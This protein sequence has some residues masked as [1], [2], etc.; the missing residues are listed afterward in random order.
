[1]KKSFIYAALALLVGLTACKPSEPTEP[2]K[3][4]VNPTSI[5]ILGG[6][7]SEVTVECTASWEATVNV[8]WL[9]VTPM[10]GKSGSTV[11]KIACKSGSPRSATVTFSSGIS[12]AQVSVSRV[13]YGH[14]DEEG[15]DLPEELTAVDLGLSS[16][17]LWANINVGGTQPEDCGSY[18]A[19]GET[20]AKDSYSWD[21]YKWGNDPFEL[22]KY[23]TDP[24]CGTVDNYSTLL[25]ADDAAT[26][27][28]GSKWRMPT[29]DEMAELLNE[30]EWRSY[31]RNGVKGYKIIG[32]NDNIIFLPAAGRIE[33]KPL[34]L[35]TGV[36]YWTSTLYDDNTNS[37]IS[38]FGTQ[39]FPSGADYI[40]EERSA[41]LPI[42][43]VRK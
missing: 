39:S 13:S 18:F 33:D 17:T 37:A 3:I 20:K 19:W 28:M 8:D 40:P 41:G 22:N 12:H 25:A 5:N 31:T 16:G 4:S 26:A 9:T 6:E 23:N 35:G 2:A 30:C 21:N 36:Y 34:G 11:V 32:P 15:E 43:A 24:A 38:L 10:S 42:R 29:A 14:K 27:N 1:M 7:E